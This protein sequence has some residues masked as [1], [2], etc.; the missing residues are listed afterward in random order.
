VG[1]YHTDRGSYCCFYCTEIKAV[2]ARIS[3]QF[4]G[5]LLLETSLC[6]RSVFQQQIWAHLSE[7]WSCTLLSELGHTV[8]TERAQFSRQIDTDFNVDLGVGFVR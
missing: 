8:S 3:R 5:H 1:L 6:R 7:F 2:T 4:C